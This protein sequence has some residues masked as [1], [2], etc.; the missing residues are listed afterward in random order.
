MD[1]FHSL[2]YKHNYTT[3]TH[4]EK[5]FIFYDRRVP[6]E[7]LPYVS[8]SWMVSSWN[9]LQRIFQGTKRFDYIEGRKTRV[10]LDT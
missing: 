5:T 2:L 3:C 7:M 8:R 4:P 6:K 1:A 10:G 9:S